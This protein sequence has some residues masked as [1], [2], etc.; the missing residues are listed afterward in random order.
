MAQAVYSVN[1]VGYINLTMKPGYN[2]V[3]N[4]LNASPNNK[5]SSV[6]GVVPDETQI[7]KFAN[8]NYSVDVYFTEFGGWI[9]P[10]GSPSTATVSPGEGFFY[11]NP[12]STD[13]AVTL[14]GEVRTGANL[15]VVH[16]PGYSLVS[17]IVPQQIAL[18]SA[19]GF[20]PVEE[21]AYLAFNSATQGYAVPLTYLSEFGGWI[22]PEG[23]PSIPTPSVGQGYFILNPGDANHTWTRSFNPNNYSQK[24]STFD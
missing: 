9:T 17:S 23:V 13:Y 11:N 5:L 24:S 19:N 8:N 1:V 21:M 15:T 20:V 14:V 18:T 2:L 7:L 22:T 10:E 12:A 6:L 3:A 4:Q 16:P